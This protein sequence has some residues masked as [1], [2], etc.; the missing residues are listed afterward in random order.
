MRSDNEKSS[1]RVELEKE[2]KSKKAITEELEVKK[3]GVRI[4]ESNEYADLQ[5]ELKA[6][7]T[8]E[9]GRKLVKELP[10]FDPSLLVEECMFEEMSKDDVEPSKTIVSES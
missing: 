10:G 7:A 1:L 3:I 8:K 5:L 4:F 9:I 6:N 2:T